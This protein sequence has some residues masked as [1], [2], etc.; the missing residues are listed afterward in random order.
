MIASVTGEVVVRRADHVVVDAS[1]VGYRLAVSTE[2]L[3]AV[4]ELGQRT[5]LYAHLVSREDSLNLYGFSSDEERLLFLSLISVSGVG[6]K[7]A[8]AALSVGP[9]S[10]IM[11]AILTGDAKR[12]Q[13]VPGIG[14]RTAERIILDLKDKVAAEIGVDP[15]GAEITAEGPVEPRT[16]ARDGLIGLGYTPLEAERLLDEG[17]GESAEEM[18]ESALRRAAGVRP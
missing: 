9:P 2:T 6:P 16:E 17:E 14:K 10:E 1:G 15:D 4:P 18:I 13:A 8:L 3:R 11:S 5:T 12:F 7:V